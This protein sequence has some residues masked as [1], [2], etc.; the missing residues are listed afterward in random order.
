MTSAGSSR[1]VESEE[2]SISITGLRNGVEYSFEV[3]AITSSGRSEGAGPVM[4]TPVTGME[5]IVAGLI[6]EF[7]NPDAV[8]EGDSII[9]GG[10]RIE[11]VSVTVTE[12]VTKDAVLVELNEPVDLATA[13][14]L[15]KDL[16]AD[17]AVAWAE[18]DQFFFTSVAPRPSDL[19]QTVTVPA[20]S[21][22]A[23]SQWNLW[24]SFG[25]SVGDGNSEMTDAWAGPRGGGVT[26]AVIDTGITA[27]PDLDGQLVSGYDFVSN[28][29]QLASS[30]QAN[31]PPVDFD[32][33]YID[34]TTYGALGRD[35]NPTDPGDWR[36]VAPLRDSSW[37]GTK[38]AGL[39]AAASNADGITG[40]APAAKVQPI[41]ALSWRG[42][43]LSDIAASITWASGGSVDGVEANESPSKVINMSFAVEAICPVAL[44]QAIDGALERR[45]ILVAAA[46]N[47]SDDA[48]KYAPGNCNGVI[49]VA[50][51]NR[52]GNRA[53]YS[54]YGDTI[55]ISAPGGDRANSVITTSNTGTQT[56]DQPATA[57]DSGTSIAA[58]HVSAA[59]AILASRNASITP[60]DAHTKLTGSDFTKAFYNETCD[61]TN[62]DIA[63]GTG[64]L[65]LAQP[66]SGSC[67]YRSSTDGGFTVVI[68]S[69]PGACSW[70]APSHVTSADVLVVGGGGGGGAWFGGGGGGGGV[71]QSN[72]QS[73][74][75]G[76]SY[77]VSVGAGGSGARMGPGGS[78]ASLPFTAGTNGGPSSL[79]LG[80]T[81]L[82]TALGGGVGGTGY[83]QAAGTGSGVATGGGGSNNDMG[84]GEGS[85][86]SGGVSPQNG[87]PHPAGGGGGAGANGTAGSAVAP[88][89][90]GAGGAGVLSTIIGA[91]I[92]YGGGGG[93]SAHGTW[94]DPSST[95]APTTNEPG[96]G[97]AGGGGNGGQATSGA[98]DSVVQ[99]G[100]GVDERG[101]GGGGA[102]NY[103]W[104]GVTGRSSIGGDGGDGVVVIRYS[105]AS[106]L[107]FASQP[108]A[109]AANGVAFT[110]QPVIQLRDSAGNA[111]AQSGVVVTAAIKTGGGTLG[112]TT[113]A[114]TNA[115]G[116]ATFSG[117]KITGTVGDRTLEFTTTS[118]VLTAVTSN[119]VSISAGAASQLV[120]TTQP[121][122]SASGAVLGTQPVIEIRDANGNT[123]TSDSLTQV[124]VAI[125]SG[126]GGTL[127]GTQTVA[128]VNGVATFTDL[129]L[130]GSVGVNYVLRFTS[131]PTLTAADSANV[132]V[133][134]GTAAKLAFSVQPSNTVA[135]SSISPAVQVTVQDAQGNTVT[136]SS[137]PITL[138]IDT[139]P[140]SG[141]LSGTATVAASSGVAT[142][143]NMSINKSGTGYTLTATSAPLAGATSSTFNITAGVAS[144]LAIMTQPVGAS[145][146]AL[147]G[148]QPVIEIRD[149]QGNLVDDDTTQVSVAITSGGGGTL[150]GTQTVTAVN[151]VATFTNLTLAGT[152]GVNYV[153]EFTSTPTLTAADSSNVTVTAGAASQLMLTTQPSASSQSGVAFAQQPVIQLRDSSGNAVSQAGV[154]VTAAIKSGGPT[155]GGTLTATTDGSGVATFSGLRITGTIGDR[156]LEFTASG[157]TAVISDAVSITPGVPS[158]LQVISGG[159]QS[160]V[161]GTA[162]ASRPVVQLRDASDN[163]VPGVT[164]T[165][166][167]TVG[168][169]SLSGTA[170]IITDINGYATAPTWTLGT[171]AGVNQLRAAGPSSLVVSVNATAL[172]G[173]AN[174]L[175]IST[176]PAAGVSG[177]LFTTQPVVQVADQ[178]GNTVTSSSTSVSV[179]SSA[180]GVVGG[181]EVSGKNASAGVAT[182]TNLTFAGVVG[183][184]YTLTFTAGALSVESAPISVTGHGAA[185][186]VGFFSAPTVATENVVISPTVQV[187]VQDSAGNTVTNATDTVS[188]AIGTNP[189]AGTLS[190]TTSV[191]A[192]A[193]L[194]SFTDLSIDNV[195]TGY[196]LTASVAGL[197]GAT[198][199]AFNVVAA[200]DASLS[201]LVVT[202]TAGAVPLTPV[203]ASGTTSYTASVLTGVTS[204]TVTPTTS[205]ASATVTVDGASVTSGNAS[206]PIPV[207]I[208][209][210]LISLVV[211]A[212][213]AV[214]TATY[215]VAI[216]RAAAPSP[217]GGGGGATSPI[218]RARVPVTPP[219]SV[220]SGTQPGGVLINGDLDSS[221]VFAANATN[222]GWS[223]SDNAFGLSV[224]MESASGLPVPMTSQGVMQ[225][226]QGGLVFLA[227]TSFLPGSELN[228]FAIPVDQTVGLSSVRVPWEITPRSTPA[229][230]SLG[231]VSVTTTGAV[232]GSLTVPITMNL[233]SYVLQINGVV[234]DDQVA[235]VNM[236]LNVVPG[237]VMM[238]S[239]M[240]REAA[241]YKGASAT[242]TAAGK[243]KLRAMVASIPSDAQGVDIAVV[244]VSVAL[245]SPRANL[246]LARERAENIVSYLKDAGVEGTVTVSLTTSF[247]LQSFMRSKASSA[248]D[249]PMVSGKGKP[250]TT[251][252]IEYEEPRT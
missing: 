154:V 66:T 63:C 25:I 132:A 105:N 38:I 208:G 86:T 234:M 214:T 73:I 206:A 72:N 163:G 164:I 11:G 125:Q 37:H 167:V 1:L 179:A 41:R 8:D 77:S 93:G 46:G 231:S 110:Q 186:Q 139:N 119:A 109:S 192:A 217:T 57:T 99:G 33:D 133:T 40:V 83:Q 17:E 35:A 115:S 162:I 111:V 155:L 114:T 142:F 79:S 237:S 250:L 180:G 48:A 34:E 118:P 241:F 42:G 113:T 166:S 171:S 49:T 55:D 197:S 98:L 87:Q 151:G 58:A 22:Y 170:D 150:A 120:I 182:F 135:G 74:S 103:W 195:G 84:P 244:G 248:N 178:Y 212:G 64:I 24:D 209:V 61:S 137:A 176:Q 187:T 140:A 9:P 203:F 146:G 76:S 13:E 26:V 138:G 128:A 221:A 169:G 130:A 70:V 52:D 210:N 161:V 7:E 213:D 172:P 159:G 211:T 175:I 95:N 129:T 6:V 177:V 116:V 251:L 226:P 198:T 188:I 141:S 107:V 36:G 43:L 16:A 29:E 68:F 47:A 15:A 201:N 80:G 112:G 136:G 96:A 50:A 215:T 173:A 235:S 51:T 60:S 94:P 81:P 106:Q 92:T 62:A 21:Q 54:N 53:S 12:N 4:A 56:P 117:L 5:N 78:L 148:T 19:A 90:S 39:I 91:G 23:T 45:S 149:A 28:P 88:F 75:P 227:G 32:G 247:D 252:A 243:A 59:A 157:L 143:S 181:G 204:V 27:H 224:R 174:Q 220:M 233:G 202:G 245:D 222:S 89:A 153:L 205:G 189:A 207:G 31:A 144:Q 127:G 184:S 194:A 168:G 10:D 246:W 97:G 30:R 147:L 236:L 216:T 20:D 242:F 238:R 239:A 229:A 3:F 249:A 100:A 240:I 82:V 199:S 160:A 225:V 85:V 108:S 134:A 123:V 232:S 121:V 218:D 124:S 14:E 183:T 65:S 193:G 185:T 126:S 230:V 190:G 102:G 228:V 152:V 18:P 101:G 191:S 145:S 165:F 69:N 156:T 104:E 131:T 122:G 219:S 196:T 71:S 44:Q 223:V 2:A 200:T 67:T 158:R